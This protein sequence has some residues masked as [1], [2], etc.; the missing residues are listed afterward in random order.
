MILR[1]IFNEI[2]VLQRTLK[3]RKEICELHVADY[4]EEE[5]YVARKKYESVKKKMFSF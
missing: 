2:F 5:A 3:V 4:E 1:W